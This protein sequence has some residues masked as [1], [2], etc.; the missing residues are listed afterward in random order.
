M[1]GIEAQWKFRSD[2]QSYW[3]LSGR[4][5]RKEYNNSDLYKLEIIVF[6]ED[7]KNLLIRDIIVI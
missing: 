4:D 5:Y 1:E 3:I 2:G 6:T 7:K